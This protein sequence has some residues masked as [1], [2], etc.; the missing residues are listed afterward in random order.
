[1]IFALFLPQHSTKNFVQEAQLS[2]TTCATSIYRR[3]ASK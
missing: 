1:M 3:K 2:P